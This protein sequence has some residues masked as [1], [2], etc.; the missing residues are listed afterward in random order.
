MGR[1]GLEVPKKGCPQVEVPKS[2]NRD[3]WAGCRGPISAAHKGT[4][5]S[6]WSPGRGDAAPGRLGALG[7]YGSVGSAPGRAEALGWCRGARCW[8]AG[9]ARWPGRSPWCVGRRKNHRPPT[10]TIEPTPPLVCDISCSPYI[11]EKFLRI[12]RPTPAPAGHVA[13]PRRA[14]TG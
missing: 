7:C 14:L 4:V 2:L 10:P 8:P 1:I 12:M 5:V 13:F 11:P 6:T 3:L 9:L